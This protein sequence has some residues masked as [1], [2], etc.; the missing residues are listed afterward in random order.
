MPIDDRIEDNKTVV[1]LRDNQKEQ[2]AAHAFSLHTIRQSFS[3]VLVSCL[4]QNLNMTGI[5]VPK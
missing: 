2:G 3:C 1:A 4:A 5:M